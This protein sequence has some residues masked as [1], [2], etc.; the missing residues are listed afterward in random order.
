MRDLPRPGLE[1]VFSALAGGFLTIAS[2]GKSKTC[3]FLKIKTQTVKVVFFTFIKFYFYQTN[4]RA[5]FKRR[6][7][8]KA[9]KIA[10][11]PNTTSC[12]PLAILFNFFNCFFWHLIL[13]FQTA[14]LYCYFLIFN[15][16]H[17]PNDVHYGRWAFSLSYPSLST[18]VPSQFPSFL[19]PANLV[20]L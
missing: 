3:I 5:S 9:Y 14:C 16:R 2:P 19:Y 17:L 20:I 13:Y 8:H 7:Y 4:I 18:L 15:F 6:K 10:P 11:S 12:S 1:L